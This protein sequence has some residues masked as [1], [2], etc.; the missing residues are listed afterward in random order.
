MSPP[1]ARTYP[2]SSPAPLSCVPNSV[3]VCVSL[4]PSGPPTVIASSYV[5]DP[6][7]SSVFSPLHSLLASLL[8]SWP[9]PFARHSPLLLSLLTCSCSWPHLLIACSAVVLVLAAVVLSPVSASSRDRPVPSPFPPP[10]LELLPPSSLGLLRPLSPPRAPLPPA[11]AADIVRRGKNISNRTGGVVARWLV[12]GGSATHGKC[13]SRPLSLVGDG[14]IRPQFLHRT[15]Q[16]HP[17]HCWPALRNSLARVDRPLVE[18]V[19]F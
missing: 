15:Q 3:A 8:P 13:P 16:Y 6:S 5:A 17:V 10:F 1:L 11:P 12:A 2:C 9:P 14:I 7:N 4:P 19:E 18:Q